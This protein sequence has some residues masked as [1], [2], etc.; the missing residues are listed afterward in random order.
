MYWLPR[1][2]RHKCGNP[3]SRIIINIHSKHRIFKYCNSDYILVFGSTFWRCVIPV[4]YGSP[5]FIRP[6]RAVASCRVLHPNNF[7]ERRKV[8]S[9][10]CESNMTKIILRNHLISESRVSSYMIY[11]HV[12]VRV[13]ARVCLCT[14]VCVCHSV[15]VRANLVSLLLTQ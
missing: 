8:K 4:K 15:S 7:T 14:C 12:L 5:Q 2:S 13:C 10:K 9:G 1:K 6:H 11:F 3:V